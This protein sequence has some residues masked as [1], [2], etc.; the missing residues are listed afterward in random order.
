MIRDAAGTVVA[1]GG[2]VAVDAAGVGRHDG[3]FVGVGD[4]GVGEDLWRGCAY[5]AGGVDVGKRGS[6]CVVEDAGAGS[7]VV[8]EEGEACGLLV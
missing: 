2:E 7:A 4:D 6:K 1:A 8:G 5:G 3:D